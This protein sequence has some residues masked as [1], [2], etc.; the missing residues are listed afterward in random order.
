VEQKL[1]NDRSAYLRYGL[2]GA[3]G[4]LILVLLYW[5]YRSG[6]AMLIVLLPFFLAI[7][8]AYILNPLVE[9]LE[10]R[11]VPRYL[12]ILLIYAIFFTLLLIIGLTTIP[13]LILELQK[14]GEK[15]PEYTRHIQQFI[16]TLQSDY[17]RINIPESIR[18]VLD[19]NII[20][21]QTAAQDVVERVTDTVLS[22]FSHT[23]TI[24][25]IPLLVYYLLRDMDSLKRSFVMLFPRRYRQWVA[26]M[27]SEMDR[28]LGAYFRGMLLICILVGIMTY[29]GLVILGVDFAL[30]LGIIAGITNIIPYFG[31]LIGA[32][33]AVLISLLSSPAL[34]LK[35]ILVFV[36]VQQIE[37]QLIAPQ[38][39]GRSLGLHPLIVIF[40]LIVGGK[41][42][43]LVG[44]IFAV[45]FTAMIRI[46]FKHAIDLAANR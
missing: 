29:L 12:G 10:N 8:L 23:F 25:I 13:T 4:A 16:L 34:A 17:R 3:S 2:I 9:F 40:V 27:G 21:L 28:T 37:S 14:L 33:P 20:E 11:H 18:L 35:V 46:F 22:L 42:F 43:G 39:L 15:I 1:N 44:L 5:L 32:V 6:A 45:P 24:L 38:V 7:I 36:I 31:P 19:Q 41:L 26:A 30:L